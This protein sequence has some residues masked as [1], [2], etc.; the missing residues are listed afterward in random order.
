MQQMNICPGG[1]YVL[2]GKADNGLE[3]NYLVLEI[4]NCSARIT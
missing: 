3:N 4:E 2:V 1:V